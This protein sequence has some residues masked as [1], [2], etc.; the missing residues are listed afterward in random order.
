M[1]RRRRIQHTGTF[2]GYCFG[3][4]AG[5]V[6]CFAKD[7]REIATPEI[8]KKKKTCSPGQRNY[9]LFVMGLGMDMGSSCF[10]NIV[11]EE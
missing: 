2:D 11:L 7:R 9:K 3:L 5:W 6:C 4:T 10:A 1:G 8:R